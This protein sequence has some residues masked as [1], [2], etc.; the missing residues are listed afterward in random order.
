MLKKQLFLFLLVISQLSVSAQDE[1]SAFSADTIK[2]HQQINESKKILFTNP[3]IADLYADTILTLSLRSNYKLG[4][5]KAYNLKGI[6][7]LNNNKLDQALIYFKKALNHSDLEENLELRAIALGNIGLTYRYQFIRDSAIYYMEKVIDYCDVNEIP[8]HSAKTIFDLAGLYI[9]SDQYIKGAKYLFDAKSGAEELKDTILLMYVHHS[10]GTLFTKLKK[11][12]QAYSSFMKVIELD[13]EVESMSLSAFTYFNIGELFFRVK[14]NDDSAYYY[15]QKSIHS[16]LPHEKEAFRLSNGVSIGNLFYHKKQYDSSFVYYRKALNH[17]LIKYFPDRKA[18]VLVNIGKYYLHVDKLD[19]ASKYL[20]LG[21]KFSDS[22]GILNYKSVALQGLYK[23]DSLK[24]NYFDALKYYQEFHQTS[25]SLLSD[26]ALH[27]IAILEFEKNLATQKYNNE[28]LIQQ[29]DIKAKQISTQRR[30]IWISFFSLIIS[31]LFIYFQFKNRKKVKR[32]H[33][34]LSKKHQDILEVNEELNISNETL[35]HQQE[36]LKALNVTKDKFF[37]IL[38]HDL[39]SPFV[40]LLGMLNLLDE[41]WNSMPDQEKH[42]AIKRL[43]AVSENNY[44][45]LEDLLSWGKAQQ[46]L[47]KNNSETFLVLPKIEQLISLFQDSISK[48]DINL[49]VDISP[50]IEL[51]TDPR[52]FIQIIQ[53]LINN[54][55][56]FT[57]NRGSVRVKLI[58]LQN[59]IQVCVEDTGIG[60]PKDQVQNIFN[61]DSNF[62]RAGTNNEKSTGMGLILSK[63]FA[64][65]LNAKFSV[66]SMEGKGSIFCLVF[67][68]T[69]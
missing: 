65:I 11:F 16:A 13:R 68:Q 52:L 28:M 39:K 49:K 2:I 4:L 43:F 54:A 20:N 56:K 23:L 67:K 55:I 29:N 69:S 62:N 30:L 3:D 61:L 26:L 33:S 51:D 19:S 37:A 7:F 64:D 5:Y 40:S 45:L 24:G 42:E 58:S 9:N 48:K 1:I 35:V 27:K 46:G 57:P 41:D 59:E 10:I 47:I 12:E 17:D 34:Q 50:D 53:N 63:E 60:I 31:L 36:Q 15:Y 38:G 22:L 44:Q 66:S 18:A 6:C 32:L 14:N 21:L 25:D 8:E